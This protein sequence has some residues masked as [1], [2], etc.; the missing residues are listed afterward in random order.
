MP[1]SV[2]FYVLKLISIKIMKKLI[3]LGLGALLI[4]TMLVINVNVFKN[5]QS[6][7]LSLKNLVTIPTAAAEQPSWYSTGES[8]H[9]RCILGSVVKRVSVDVYKWYVN[10]SVVWSSFKPSASASGGLEKRV[11]TRTEETITYG[12]EYTCRGTSGNCGVVIC[13]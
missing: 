12:S 4:M 11:E 1:T 2:K 3:Y 6:S 8:S 9:G 10:G 7:N 13:Y 5:N